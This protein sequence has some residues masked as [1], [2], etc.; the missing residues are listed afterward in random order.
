MKLVNIHKLLVLSFLLYSSLGM[1]YGQE[2]SLEACV[3]TALVRNKGLAV[4]ENEMLISRE[5]N[6]EVKSNLYPKITAKADYKYFTDLPYQLMPMSVFGGPE[7]QFKEAQFG[8]PHNINAS[9][10]VVMPLYNSQIYGA[11]EVTRIGE[12]ISEIKYL[13]SKEELVFEVSNL[14]YNGQIIRSQLFFVDSN[15]SNTARLLDNMRLLREQKMIR[16]SD[17]KKVQL[18]YEQLETQ[19]MILESKYEQLMSALKFAIGIPANRPFDVAFSIIHDDT[20]EYEA[21][22]TL[23]MRLVMTQSRFLQSEISTLKNSRLPSV[24]L[25]GSYGYMGYGYDEKPNDFLNF[26]PVS[27]AGVQLSYTLFNGNVTRKKIIQ[28]EY[29]LENARLQ[30]DLLEDKTRMQ[31]AN[32]ELR[33]R[34]AAKSIETSLH[35]IELAQDVYNQSI[36]QQ[37]EGTAALS[38]VLLAD[39]ALREAQQSYLAAVIE[40]MKADLELKKFSGNILSKKRK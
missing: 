25:I 33:L 13:K 12:E 10:Q 26:Y 4:A 24:A 2:W 29:Q 5:K 1:V 39:T 37:R 7:G 15:L 16:D 18:Q 9:V 27:F 35:Q 6:K 34:T 38:D 32:A 3:D 31:R 11:I 19:K 40:Y 28:K 22:S 20:A 17:L 23:D 30:Y 36:V 14:Y 8:V 21:K